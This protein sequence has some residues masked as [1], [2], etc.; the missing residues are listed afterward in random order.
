MFGVSALAMH[1]MCLIL[2]KHVKKLGKG[3]PRLTRAPFLYELV[4]LSAEIKG[5]ATMQAEDSG[6]RL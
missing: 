5:D 6:A 3:L 1:R 2:S 4:S